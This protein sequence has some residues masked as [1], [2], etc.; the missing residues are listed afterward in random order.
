V[1]TLSGW[2]SR[3]FGRLRMADL[4]GPKCGATISADEVTEKCRSSI[5]LAPCNLALKCHQ[6]DLL[7]GRDCLGLSRMRPCCGERRT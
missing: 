1:V 5:H 7:T 3:F 2:H 6:N 4:K